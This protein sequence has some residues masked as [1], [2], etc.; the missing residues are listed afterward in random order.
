MK[1]QGLNLRRVSSGFTLIEL[2]VVITILGILA[3][4]ALPRFVAL[5]RD[6][7]IAKLNAARGAVVA[8]NAVVHSAILTRANVA[9]V[10]ASCAGGTTA[11]NLTGAAG[12]VC[13]ETGLIATV[14]G[15]PE[16]AAFGAAPP[17]IL[18]AAGLSQ[19]ISPVAADLTAEGYTVP[20]PAAGLTT[21]Q[22]ASA[23]NPAT[24]LFTYAQATGTVAVPPVITPPVISAVT[25]TGC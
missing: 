10:A 3:A 11:N 23:P 21:F 14:Y 20:V 8:A 24:C 1:G 19:V 17:G 5:Q 7:R 12:T 15:Y 25:T 4:V 22:I 6:A 16:S 18:G 9:D 13:A 2:V